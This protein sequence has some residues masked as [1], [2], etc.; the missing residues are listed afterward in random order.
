MI[1]Y[2]EVRYDEY[3]GFISSIHTEETLHS[4]VKFTFDD[5]GTLIDAE[6][7]GESV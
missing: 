5:N 1:V 2:T 7:V 4:N 6:F 3:V